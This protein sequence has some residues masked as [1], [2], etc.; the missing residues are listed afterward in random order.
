M[1]YLETH[2]DCVSFLLWFRNHVK[3][4]VFDNDLSM[5]I[6]MRRQRMANY[7]KYRNDHLG[8]TPSE[9]CCDQLK[10]TLK[11]LPPLYE[12]DY[13]IHYSSI[14][15]QVDLFLN[16][17]KMMFLLQPIQKHEIPIF[18]S[19]KRDGDT[20]SMNKYRV[21]LT[22]K[23]QPAN[24]PSRPRS[25]VASHYS[26]EEGSIVQTVI[27]TNSQSKP[28]RNNSLQCLS[29]PFIPHIS[30][31]NTNN[32]NINNNNINNNSNYSNN[33][34]NLNLN[35]Y[36]FP[37][38]PLYSP[39]CITESNVSHSFIPIPGAIDELSPKP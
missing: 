7:I 21:E 31:T 30:F 17:Y 32:N 2:G 12:H 8:K 24:R 27:S 36:T 29:K 38:R 1:E 11:K 37:T 20:L 34:N 23:C 22:A 15:E 16:K 19:L 5:D 25:L 9:S 14:K 33:G 18:E 39:S 4:C 28:S 3:Q 26:S 10:R 6:A 35:K 13:E